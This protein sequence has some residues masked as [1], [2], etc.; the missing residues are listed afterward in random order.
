MHIR[1]YVQ[2]WKVVV[3][4]RGQEVTQLFDDELSMS[5]RIGYQAGDALIDAHL[6]PPVRPDHNHALIVDP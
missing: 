1:P 3:S 6:R 4:P 5:V 2:L